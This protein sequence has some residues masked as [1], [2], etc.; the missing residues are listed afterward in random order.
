MI[1]RTICDTLE[2]MRKCYETR[3]F[4][5][6]LGL[7]EEAQTLANR[8]EAKLYDVREIENL[9]E[10]ISELTEEKDE[11][12]K[13]IKKLDKEVNKYPNVPKPKSIPEPYHK[14]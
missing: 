2:E 11:L 8:M 1:N 9:R 14:I 12:R 5:Y 10:M 6:I 7:I 4:S 13:Q 3:N